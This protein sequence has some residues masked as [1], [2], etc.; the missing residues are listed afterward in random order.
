MVIERET[1]KNMAEIVMAYFILF[2]II[3]LFDLF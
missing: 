2:Y 1:P 3:T